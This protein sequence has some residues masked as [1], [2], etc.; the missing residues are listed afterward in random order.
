MRMTFH[1]AAG[2]VTGSKSLVETDTARILVDC[3]LYQGLKNLRERNWAPPPFDPRELDA[4]VLTHAHIDHSGYLPVLVQRG[5]RGPIHCTD[6]TADLLRILLPDA[7]YLQEEDARF[8]N[9]HG[10]SRHRPALPLY[11]RSDVERTL[12]LLR[13]HAWDEPFEVAGVSV[14]FLRAGHILGAATVH[15]TRGHRRISFSGDVGR[16][17]D[18]LFHPPHP[19]PES[20]L[21]VME[22]TYG[23][24]LH[25]E[26]DPAERLAEV[27]NQ[28]AARKGVLLV[29]AFAVGRAQVLLHLFAKLTREGRI[30]RIPTYLDSPMA[31]SVTDLFV[32]HRDEHRLTEAACQHMLETTTFVRDVEGSKRLDQGGG[33]KIIV[34]GSGMAT[35]GR[36]VHH[37]KVFGPDP[38]NAVLLSGYQAA[39]TRGEALIRGVSEIKIHGMYYPIRAERLILHGLSGHADQQEMLAWLRQGGRPGRI[40]VNH[41]EPTAADTFRR[42]LAEVFQVPVRVAEPGESFHVYPSGHATE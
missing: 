7:A 13:R 21:L 22:S 1:G 37:L 18:L 29:P 19:L 24:R 30:P 20:D 5:F 9:R 12:P 6:A 38:K 2:T 25:D 34:A 23:D 16:P 32:R 42:H 33:P 26:A 27:V 11:D 10:F 40:V 31:I 41:G 3:G 17:Q 14:R 39:G 4:V 8:A 15:L 35:G 36:I 28:V